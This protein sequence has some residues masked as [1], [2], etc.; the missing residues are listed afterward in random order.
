M[1]INQ[2]NIAF[3]T[4]T[5]TIAVAGQALALDK[6]PEKDGLSGYVTLGVSSTS[7]SSNMISG[8]DFGDI[9][10]ETIDSLEKS[11]GSEDLTSGFFTGEV[12][13]TFADTRTQLFLG[14][15]LEDMVRYDFG[16][17]AGI[18]QE[19]SNNGVVSGAILFSGMPANVWA[20][21]YVVNQERKETERDSSGGR[22][23]WSGAMGTGLEVRVSRRTIDIDDEFS[24]L[25]P[26][27][28][29]GLGLTQAQTESLSREGDQTS[30]DASYTF[31]FGQGHSLIPKITF[32]QMDLDGDAMSRD[33][34]GFQLAYAYQTRRF[35]LVTTGIVS[36]SD[37]DEEN[38]LYGK[39]QEVDTLGVTFLGA[40]HQ[41]FG[42]KG[43]SA[44]ASVAVLDADSN[45][46]FYDTEVT[47]VS[48]G[49]LYRFN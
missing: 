1:R 18:R 41:P 9:G 16:F 40:Y 28:L 24:G 48:L 14:N 33:Q 22:I 46:D 36:S 30:L 13:Y 5:V 20:D 35:S 43:W 42:L 25:T 45:I 31:D 17:Q 29:G 27:T 10:D 12:N 19:V 8:S 21:P 49:M 38:P 15:S 47:M 7:F 3:L 44:I 4:A 11:P 39:K 34:L 32:T 2:R 26:T 37:Y 23:A 6:I